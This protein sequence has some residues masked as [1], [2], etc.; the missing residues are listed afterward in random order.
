[1]PPVYWY[2]YFRS[3]FNEDTWKDSLGEKKKK[4]WIKKL[5]NPTFLHLLQSAKLNSSVHFTSA[6]ELIYIL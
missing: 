1:M 3:G 6:Q 5:R 2:H 4:G